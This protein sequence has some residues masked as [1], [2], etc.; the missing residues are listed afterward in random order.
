MMTSEPAAP[1]PSEV[2]EGSES[3]SSQDWPIEALAGTWKMYSPT[4]TL[5][6]AWLKTVSWAWEVAMRSWLA[7]G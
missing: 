3:W 1:M 7:A 5:P 2:A 4:I 6:P